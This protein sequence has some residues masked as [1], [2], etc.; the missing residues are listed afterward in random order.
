MPQHGQKQ[1]KKKGG[2]LDAAIAYEHIDDDI[3][4]VLIVFEDMGIS[5][6]VWILK[7]FNHDI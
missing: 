7:I 6:G 3:G 1:K 4:E 2:S 5:N